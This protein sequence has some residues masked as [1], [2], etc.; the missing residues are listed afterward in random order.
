M[1]NVKLFA[2]FDDGA[3]LELGDVVEISADPQDIFD[4]FDFNILYQPE[5]VKGVFEL[6]HTLTVDG[7]Q[8]KIKLK[9]FGLS[10]NY[11][12]LHGGKPLRTV[13]KRFL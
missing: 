4:P 11:I 3:K 10:N 6:S 13:R 1:R 12:R 7:F 2:V 5:R 9:L 8:P